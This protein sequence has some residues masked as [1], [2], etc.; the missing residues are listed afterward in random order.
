MENYAKIKENL[1]SISKYEGLLANVK[2]MDRLGFFKWQ[3]PGLKS[4]FRK[5]LPLSKKILSKK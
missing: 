2:Q 4:V 3:K 5:V 1:S